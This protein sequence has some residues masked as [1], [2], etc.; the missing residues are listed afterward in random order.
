MIKIN[1]MEIAETEIQYGVRWAD[2]AVNW[3]RGWTEDNVEELGD[4]VWATEGAT[5]LRRH[6]FMGA[7]ESVSP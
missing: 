1:G 4:I 6:I 5:L 7:P 2:G 3:Y